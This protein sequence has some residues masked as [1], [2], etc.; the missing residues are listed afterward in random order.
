VHLRGSGRV[1]SPPQHDERRVRRIEG[2]D[3]GGIHPVPALA[4]RRQRHAR[5]VARR[6]GPG[7]HWAVPVDAEGDLL[8]RSEAVPVGGH[9]RGGR[10]ELEP[11]PVHLRMNGG[12]RDRERHRHGCRAGTRRGHGRDPGRRIRRDTQPGVR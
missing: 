11:W 5:D 12:S 8:V 1:R 2:P 9:T 10:R 4:V 7:D 6:V 3:P